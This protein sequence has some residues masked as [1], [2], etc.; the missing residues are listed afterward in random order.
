M[1]DH[2]ACT[3]ALWCARF[4]SGCCLDVPVVIICMRVCVQVLGVTYCKKRSAHHACVSYSCVPLSAPQVIAHVRQRYPVSTLYAAGWSL[5]MSL[6]AL[7]V[8][9][10]HALSC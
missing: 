9:L 10:C 5:H 6:W 3:P 7:H 2:R 4:C 8:S 1:A